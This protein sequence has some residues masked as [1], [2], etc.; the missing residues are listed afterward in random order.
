MADKGKAVI[1]WLYA[2]AVIVVPF[3]EGS[4]REPS[5]AEGVQIAIAVVTAFG[6][7]IAPIIP[8]ATWIKTAIGAILAGLQ[9][10]V[11][12]IVDGVS[13]ND[14]LMIVFAV[15]SALGIYL[16][17]AKSSNGVA[18]GWGSDKQLYGL[19]A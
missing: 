8:G 2:I 9:I 16:A 15:A 3:F 6:V 17:P 10:L 18:V 1:A 13:G 5:P 4:G 19:A 11:S 14:V 7:H 12:V